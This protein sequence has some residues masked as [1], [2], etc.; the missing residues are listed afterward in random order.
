MARR[1]QNQYS[2]GLCVRYSKRHTRI[3]A[4]V[5]GTETLTSA[6][7]PLIAATE[8]KI[9]AKKTAEDTR[10]SNYDLLMFADGE[11]DNKVRDTAAACKEYDRNNPGA[12]TYETVFPENTKPIIDANPADEPAEVTKVVSRLQSLGS[13]HVLAAFIPSLTESAEKVS[14]YSNKYLTAIS[15]VGKADAD[16]Q[17]AKANLIR[18]YT[19]NMFEAEKMFG[20][21]YASRL[22]P[23][24]INTPESDDDED[25]PLK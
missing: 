23:K 5:A 11:L 15:Q 17:I 18:Q 3:N 9:A 24:I 13:N 7:V 21:K 14:E 19:F 16:L 12:R 10:D 22:F 25:K 4:Q 6:I 20:R 1:L 8:E 2:P